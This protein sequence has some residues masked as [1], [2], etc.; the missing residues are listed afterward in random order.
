MKEKKNDMKPKKAAALQYDMDK[1][2]APRIIAKG[3]GDIARKIIEK[4]KE[5]DIY[6]DNNQDLV[7]ILLKLEIGEEI[8]PELYQVVAEILSFIYQLE[9]M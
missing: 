9:E 1:D 6:I 4:A 7:E 2:N 5:E 8:P 3:R